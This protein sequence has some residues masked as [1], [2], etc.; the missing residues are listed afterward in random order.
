MSQVFLGQII[1]GGW[2]FPP[3]GFH[4]CDGSL[5]SIA[6]N[7]ALFSLLGTNYGGNGTT[8]FALRDLRG[9]AAINWGQGP[10]LQN[11]VIGETIGVESTT[12]TIL[13]M[14]IHNHTATFTSTGGTMN[15]TLN[16]ATSQDP[17]AGGYLAQSIEG[18]PGNNSLPRIY[19]PAGGTPSFA[20]LAGVNAAGTVTV[21][22]NGG[23]Q[24]F[25]VLGPRLAVSIVIALSGIFPSRN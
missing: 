8:T 9:R 6:Q 13:N 10:G 3:R 14:P 12:L 5:L 1:H 19:R 21:N 7:T 11:Y 2:N 22:T 23:S 15:A 25:N 18:Q 20:A 24:P 4:M 17:V 16:K